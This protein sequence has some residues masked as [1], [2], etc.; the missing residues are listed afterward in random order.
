MIFLFLSSSSCPESEG[1]QC[2]EKGKVTLELF[3]NA[4]KSRVDD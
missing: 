1:A 4:S 3:P 2:E